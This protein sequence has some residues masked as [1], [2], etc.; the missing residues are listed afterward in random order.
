M[1]R[2][3]QYSLASCL[4]ALS[5]GM[6]M[7]DVKL[8]AIFNDNMVLQREHKV[9]VWGT[10]SPGEAITVSILGQ[11]VSTKAD[12]QGKWRVNLSPLS[13]GGPHELKVVANNSITFKNVL[14]GEVWVCS[15]QSNMEWSVK[16]CKDAE[17][18]IAN[19]NHPQIRLVIVTKT[20]ADA[21]QADFVPQLKWSECSPKTVAGF[22]AVAYYFG[23]E[24]HKRL[25]VPVG[26]IE[27]CW[28]GTLCEAWTSHATLASDA[29][30]A[31]IL[32]RRN[33][34]VAKFP[35]AL[36]KYEADLQAWKK[37]SLTEEGKHAPKPVMPQNPHKNPNFASNLYNG[38]LSPV[39]PYGIRGAI[40]YQGES[41]VDRAHQYRKLFP[42]MI[43][44]WRKQW[45]QGDFPFHFVQLAN[46][47]A[48][49][50]QP[51]ESAW[52]ELREAQAMTLKT[53]HTGMAVIIDIGD[54][55]DIHPKN[56]QDVGLRLA[57]NA[58]AQNYGQKIEYSGPVYESMSVEGNSVR[59][60]FQHV[61]NGLVA[62]GGELKGF[63]ICGKDKKFV[64]ATAKIDGKAIVVSAPGVQEPV[65]VRYAWA[66]NPVCNLYN[67]EG[68]PASPFRTDSFPGLTVGKK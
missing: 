48:V 63:A 40:W 24:L 31:P 59:L 32:I 5:A 58:L 7:A 23:R 34:A 53:P 50:D 19:A 66:D 60:K 49:K 52:A 2:R 42:A 10:A 3:L 37:V 6:A 51:G 61:G 57:L 44:D 54:A 67:Q 11:Q 38:M 35:R 36:E 16:L 55:K 12:A 25:N 28:G 41:N 1:L 21:P 43:T 46:F 15:G 45:G 13:A 4:L 30:F 17:L 14:V 18:E 33:F 62:K 65:A 64:W 26:L 56:K 68:I 39:I 47:L 22:S 8:P 9:P 27:D 29:D 20:V